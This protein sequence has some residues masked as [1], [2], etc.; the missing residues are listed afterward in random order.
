M[1]LIAKNSSSD[2][3]TSE[4]H[5]EKTSTHLDHNVA[6]KQLNFVVETVNCK[7]LVSHAVIRIM[8]LHETTYDSCSKFVVEFI[9]TLQQQD[10]F[11]VKLRLSEMKNI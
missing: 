2:I 7:Q 5:N 9:K 10:E 3:K 8:M 6:E 11:V 4:S 1:A